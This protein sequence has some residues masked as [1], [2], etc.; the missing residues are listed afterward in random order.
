MSFLNDPKYAFIRE[1]KFTTEVTLFETTDK[2]GN[3][4]TRKRV[5]FIKEYPQPT[6][7]VEAKKLSSRRP[8]KMKK[9]KKDSF[10]PLFD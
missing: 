10:V 6:I 2:D 4:V 9:T 8:K 3:T 7:K 5:K 1:G